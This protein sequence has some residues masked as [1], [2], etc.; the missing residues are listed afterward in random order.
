MLRMATFILM[1]NLISQKC[2][3]SI[4]IQVLLNQSRQMNQMTYQMKMMKSGMITLKYLRSIIQKNQSRKIIQMI[5]QKMLMMMT[6]MT[7]QKFL[8]FM[9]MTNQKI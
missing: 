2:L 3:S 9:M 1:I 8:R 5:Y 6:G 4:I 7:K